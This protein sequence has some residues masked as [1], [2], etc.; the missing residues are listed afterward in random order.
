MNY[1]TTYKLC[2]KIIILCKHLSKA[3]LFYSYEILT[4]YTNELHFYIH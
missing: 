4:N 3:F 2:L 1:S